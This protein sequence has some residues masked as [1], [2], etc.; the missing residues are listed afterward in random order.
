MFRTTLLSLFSSRANPRLICL[1]VFIE[2]LTFLSF[3]W[4]L[5]WDSQHRTINQN[6]SFFCCWRCQAI[7]MHL[8]N[9]LLPVF[10]F[11]DVVVAVVCLFGFFLFLRQEN[12]NWLPSCW[13]LTDR[14]QTSAWLIICGHLVLKMSASDKHW[15]PRKLRDLELHSLLMQLGGKHWILI[16]VYL[17]LCSFVWSYC[18]QLP[19]GDDLSSTASES[20]GSSSS[21]S[22]VRVAQV[23][24]RERERVRS[25][26][27]CEV[28][29]YVRRV[30]KILKRSQCSFTIT[31]QICVNE[32]AMAACI[33]C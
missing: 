10:C 18:K 14:C 33:F 22:F 23:A 1:Q 17:A 8:I 28:E 4:E 21:G 9:D 7:Q 31:I 16:H 6:A 29:P 24:T 32:C 13:W 19:P 27:E 26:N 25:W 11:F 15:I 3:V 30:V 20:P 2:I 5:L 12:Q